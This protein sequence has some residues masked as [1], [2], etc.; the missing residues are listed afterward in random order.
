MKL[1][2]LFSGSALALHYTLFDCFLLNSEREGYC[3]A[4]SCGVLRCGKALGGIVSGSVKS[5]G[6]PAESVDSVMQN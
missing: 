3:A 2:A 6:T 4:V 1:P 5:V